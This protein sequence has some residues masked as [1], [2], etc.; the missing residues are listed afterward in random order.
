MVLLIVASSL[1]AVIYVWKIIEAAYIGQAPE[2]RVPV[3]EAPLE[4]LIPLWVLVLANIYFGID[5]ELTTS[6]AGR[7][8]ETFLG[9]GS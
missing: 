8:A 6:V 9:G 2:G 7:V 4:M 5:A 1:L 3:A